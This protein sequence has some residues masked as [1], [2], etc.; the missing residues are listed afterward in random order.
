MLDVDLS[1][2][3][4]RG[5][6]S[7]DQSQ[8]AAQRATGSTV[9]YLLAL[10][11]VDAEKAIFTTEFSSFYATLTAA[12]APPAGPTSGRDPQNVLAEEPNVAFNR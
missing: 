8:P 2:P 3:P 1:I 4:R 11:T 7:T 6:A 5:S 9:T 12:D 10:S